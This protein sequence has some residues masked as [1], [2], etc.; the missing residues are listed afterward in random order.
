M[1]NNSEPNDARSTAKGGAVTIEDEPIVKGC[2]GCHQSLAPSS[3]SGAQLKLKG[4]RKCKACIQQQQQLSTEAQ[5]DSSAAVSSVASSAA[6]SASASSTAKLSFPHSASAAH[7]AT[8]A[9][10][11]PTSCSV[12]GNQRGKLRA[13]SRCASVYCGLTCLKQHSGSGLCDAAR[14]LPP[15]DGIAE[16]DRLS[17]EELAKLWPPLQRVCMQRQEENQRIEQA[18]PPSPEHRA[19][20]FDVSFGAAELAPLVELYPPRLAA[21]VVAPSLR[22]PSISQCSRCVACVDS[23]RRRDSVLG[24]SVWRNPGVTLSRLGSAATGTGFHGLH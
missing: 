11:P 23:S 17:V 10:E 20:V 15:L 18:C 9:D 6:A 21:D 2:S 24:Q 19:Q 3:F 4:K 1:E 5:S 8:A 14:S 16:E 7:S 13:C 12:C 22:P